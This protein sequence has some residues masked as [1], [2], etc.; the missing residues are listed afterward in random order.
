MSPDTILFGL[1]MVFP[2]VSSPIRLL[3][4]VGLL[5]STQRYRG[6]TVKLPASYRPQL[7][8]SPYPLLS[9]GRRLLP[10]VRR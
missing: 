3:Q 2:P 10:I 1:T 8:G 9:T 4:S 5:N 6:I 7:F